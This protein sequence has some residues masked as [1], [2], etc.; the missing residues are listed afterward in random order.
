LPLPAEPD[1]QATLLKL[2]AIKVVNSH[3]EGGMFLIRAAFWLSVAILFIPGDQ[4]S[5]APRVSMVN[6]LVAARATVADLSGFCQR[7]PDVC[8]TGGTAVDVFTDKAGNGVRMLYRYLNDDETATGQGTL[9]E[10]DVV[11]PWQ[12]PASSDSA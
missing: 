8:V 9:T 10:D 5:D 6:A 2:S 4:S 3:Y 7:N 12:G 1:L 11:L